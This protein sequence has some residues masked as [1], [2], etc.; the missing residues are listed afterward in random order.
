M[1]NNLPVKKGVSRKRRAN[2]VHKD[3]TGRSSRS[4]KSTAASV[5]SRIRSVGNSKGIILSNELLKKAGFSENADIL[6]TSKNGQILIIEI[7]SEE[8]VNT[9][10]SSW[11][12]QFKEAIKNGAIPEKDLFKGIPNDFDQNDWAA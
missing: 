1:N 8:R 12:R 6:L 4:N 2:D 10:L 3:N 7:K 5:R 9:D 11:E